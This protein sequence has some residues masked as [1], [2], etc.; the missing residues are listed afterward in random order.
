[1]VRFS[2]A[3]GYPS[4]GSDTAN[5]ATQGAGRSARV[6]PPHYF[7]PRFLTSCTHPGTRNWTN[8]NVAPG[9]RGDCHDHRWT[10]GVW[11]LAQMASLAAAG[12]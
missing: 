4:P 6:N 12:A 2:A 10:G 7:S 8:V 5:I 1:M 9:R 3:V 11:R